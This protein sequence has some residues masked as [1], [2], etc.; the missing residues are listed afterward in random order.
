[1]HSSPLEEDKLKVTGFMIDEIDELCPATTIDRDIISVVNIVHAAIDKLKW[2]PTGES[3]KDLKLKAPIGNAIGPCL[4]DIGTHDVDATESM[5]ADNMTDWKKE[6][7]P[8]NSVQGMVNF[9][10][11]PQDT[12]QRSWKYYE[13]AAAFAKR[14]SN[15]RFCVT[16][17]GYLGFAPPEAHLGDVICVLHGGAVPF[18]LRRTFSHDSEHRLI[19]EC[20]IHGIMY[21]EALSFDGIEERSFFL[22]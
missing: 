14:L 1:M 16:K 21:G 18:V 17:R 12:R 22:V 13:T 3:L 9:L 4:D 6:I 2:Y 5:S 7:S 19:G 11:K 20:Y 15:G 8:I 10:K